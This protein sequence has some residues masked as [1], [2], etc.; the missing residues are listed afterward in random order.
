MTVYLL[1]T[2]SLLPPPNVYHSDTITIC[3]R[4]K[5]PPLTRTSKIPFIFDIPGKIKGILLMRVRG[6]VFVRPQIAFVSL[7]Y[8][9][10]GGSRLD[11]GSK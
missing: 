5:N 11:V 9:F 6:G 3:G 4:T 2:S 7:W 8:T 1:P 10:G